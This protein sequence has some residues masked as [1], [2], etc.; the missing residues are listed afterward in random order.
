MVDTLVFELDIYRRCIVVRALN[1][2]YD[3]QNRSLLT[4][5]SGPRGFYSVAPDTL[6]WT[7]KRV[8]KERN[9]MRI[10][11]VRTIQLRRHA[12]SF[13]GMSRVEYIVAKLPNCHRAR[14]SYPVLHTCWTL[15]PRTH[16][17]RGQPGCIYIVTHPSQGYTTLYRL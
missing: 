8:S 9:T 7:G 1:V 10:V 4:S 2:G 16:L 6:V 13:L 14:G 17:S 12:R 15:T 3:L 11:C 5:P